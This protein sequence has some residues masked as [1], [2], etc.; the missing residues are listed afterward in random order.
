MKKLYIILISVLLF[1]CG[2]TSNEIENSTQISMHWMK[3]Q[4]EKDEVIFLRINSTDSTFVA[5]WMMTGS[6]NEINFF[7]KIT[8]SGKY[9]IMNKG[10]TFA[11]NGDITS[12][13]VKINDGRTIKGPVD[14]NPNLK[15]NT[16]DNSLS[17]YG[18]VLN[19][20]NSDSQAELDELLDKFSAWK[21]DYI[22]LDNK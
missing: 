21:G 10:Q 9:T 5:H 6:K 4:I 19:I 18:E 20:D 22:P 16:K 17:Y 13:E 14:T 3:Y 1:A 8:F 7:G 11:L 15:F 2:T 12:N